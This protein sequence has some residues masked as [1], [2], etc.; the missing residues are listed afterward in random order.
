MGGSAPRLIEPL[1]PP[2]DAARD[3]VVERHLRHERRVFPVRELH[4]LIDVGRRRLGLE[5]VAGRIAED[6]GVAGRITD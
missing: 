6:R 3:R 2:N 4:E 5:R 1:D